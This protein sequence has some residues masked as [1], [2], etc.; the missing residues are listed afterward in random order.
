M[1]TANLRPK[2]STI[3]S[4]FLAWHAI[5]AL[6]RIE[7]KSSG[8]KTEIITCVAGAGIEPTQAYTVSR[9]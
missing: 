6:F 1:I 2:T 8:Y 7:L 5:E 4:S 3:S 9:L